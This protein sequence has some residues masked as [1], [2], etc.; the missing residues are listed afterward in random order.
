MLEWIDARDNAIL[1]D[2][3]KN[4]ALNVKSFSESF[5]FLINDNLIIVK[6][7]TNPNELLI[8]DT[9]Q[10]MEEIVSKQWLVENNVS[11]QNFMTPYE[12]FDRES[13]ISEY[14]LTIFLSFLI[15]LF[16]AYFF[17]RKYYKIDT[18]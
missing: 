2:G 12:Y 5:K 11:E 10:K 14:I 17:N 15:A 3:K 6:K 18:K 4:I 1:T 9:I 8:I 16:G 13:E 7:S